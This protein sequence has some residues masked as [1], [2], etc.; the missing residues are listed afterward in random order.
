M[1]GNMIAITD[2]T[3]AVAAKFAYTPFGEVIER[4]IVQPECDI[5]VGFAGQYGILREPNGII[6]I[7]NYVTA[8]AG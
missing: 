6:V 8:E 2:D 5:P 4:M 7:S 3:G 1:S